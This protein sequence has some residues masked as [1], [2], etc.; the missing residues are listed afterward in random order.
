MLRIARPSDDLD[1]LLPFYRDGLGPS[2][3]FRVSDHDG[4]DD[5]ILGSDGAPSGR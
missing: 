1:G 5:V 2:V 3:L 4:F